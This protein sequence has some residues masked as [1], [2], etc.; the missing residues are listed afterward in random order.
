MQPDNEYYLGSD[1]LN[2]CEA[3][4]QKVAITNKDE[5][6]RRNQY[7]LSKI[8][9]DIVVGKLAEWGVYMIYLMQNKSLHSCPDMT[10]YDKSQKSFDPDLKWG[11]FNLHIKSQT[12]ESASRYGNSWLFQSSDP[13][14]SFNNEYDIVIGCRVSIDSFERGALVEILIQKPFKNLT[15]GDTKLNKFSGNKKAIYL[16]DNNE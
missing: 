11:L 2:I 6:S 5:Y 1:I 4:A 9:K 15:F 10:V 7:N 3:F 12:D 8:K 13:L 14:F 16:E